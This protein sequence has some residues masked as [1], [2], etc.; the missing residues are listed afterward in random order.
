MLAIMGGVKK[1]N[2]IKSESSDEF[3]E[4]FRAMFELNYWGIFK[5]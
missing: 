2:Q 4:C 5:F 1:W 3:F